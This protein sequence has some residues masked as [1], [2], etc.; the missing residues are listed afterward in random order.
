MNARTLPRTLFVVALIFACSDGLAAQKKGKPPA[1]VP[2]PF[3]IPDPCVSSTLQDLGACGDGFGIYEHDTDGTVILNVN[4]EM[5]ASLSG[6]R[7]VSVDFSHAVPDTAL[8]GTA[9]SL[10]FAGQ[11]IQRTIMQTNV[12]DTAG[13][14]VSDGLMS[15]QLNE[16]KHARF[17]FTFNDPSG[18]DFHWSLRYYPELYPGSN[19][20]R[21]TRIGECTWTIHSQG[22]H[23]GGLIAY[24]VNKG[25]DSSSK[26]GIFEVPF[27]LTFTTCTH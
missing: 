27:E 18:R 6:A 17:F 1:D 14:E 13:N 15:L 8:C 26:E 24:G 11:T 20:A 12:V 7:F 19:Y 2:G 22:E 9:C 25:K 3:T 23:R 16:Q 4:R 21:V 5:R 10:N